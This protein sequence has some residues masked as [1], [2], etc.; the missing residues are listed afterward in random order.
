VGG[1]GSSSRTS[2]EQAGVAEVLGN[3]HFLY[4]WSAQAISQTAQNAILYALMV[5][6][7]E[8][9]SSSIQMSFLI[10]STILPSVVFGVTAGVFVDRWR[11]KRVLMATNLLRALAVLGFVLFERT[12]SMIFAVNAAF[13]TI[14]QFFA[15]AE[16]AAI[17]TIVSRRQLIAANGLFNLTFT[18]SQLAGFV[19]I[20]PP[21]VKLLGS[22]TFFV[23]VAVVFVVCALLVAMLPGTEVIERSTLSYQDSLIGGVRR[24][25]NDGLR[26]LRGDTAISL[27]V[28]HL[29]LAGSLMLIMAML[30]PG[31][32]SREVG[33]SARDAVYVLAP[34][35]LG[36]VAG[37]M[38]LP[39]ITR[40]W[41]KEM[42]AEAGLWVMGIALLALGAAPRIWRTVSDGLG[43]LG[44]VGL[45]GVV[46]ALAVIVGVS[47][48]LINVP[49][50]T[51]IQ[52]KAPVDMRGRLFA[53]QLALANVVSILPLVFLGGLA[54]FIGITAVI[55]LVAGFVFGTGLLSHYWNRGV[56]FLPTG[57]GSADA[58]AGESEGSHTGGEAGG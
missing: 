1:G 18:S 28:L 33:V 22:Q 58:S 57:A 42:V 41:P 27:A 26:L 50:Q 48:A 31:Y 44:L 25:L 51:V 2:Q 16:V 5:F 32:V 54:D 39:A 12:P 13:F 34:A 4:L 14:S 17:P 21:L 46:M 35:G 20:A 53:T 29:T 3:R 11:K 52:E 24:E 37:I 40:R 6:I 43:P 47:Y 15:P 55:M 36:I 10:L 23:V 30:A 7:E 38:G 8:T 19:I 49:A 45:V 56:M 9:T